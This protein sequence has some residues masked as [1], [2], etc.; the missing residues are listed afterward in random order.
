MNKIKEKIIEI[1]EKPV[2]IK[3]VAVIVLVTILVSRPSGIYIVSS[4][5]KLHRL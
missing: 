1:G 2:P 4:S 5:Q 3:H